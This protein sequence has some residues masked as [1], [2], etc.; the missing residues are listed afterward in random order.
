MVSGETAERERGVGLEL[1]DEDLGRLRYGAAY[2][3]QLARHA[4]VLA[5][6]ER[7]S[8]SAGVIL[9]VE[10]EPVVTIGKRPESPGH[11]LVDEAGL[12]ARGV[13]LC[14]T[15]RGGDVTYHGPGQLVV[16]P[17]VDLKRLGL[18]LHAY[19]RALEEAVI[20][21]LGVFGVP[22]ER[23]ATATG[24]WVRRGDGEPAKVCAMGVRVRRWVSLH[25][26]ALNVTTD[27][28]GFGVIVPCGLAGRPVTSVAELLGS[29]P[30]G[31]SGPAVTAEAVRPVLVERV[32]RALLADG[33]AG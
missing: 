17:V 2:E 20:E 3:A 14:R 21:T 29:G 8:A 28:R 12:R 15:D 23:D 25:G 24:V 1:A 18:G 11:L 13:E 16:Y 4:E 22:G 6:R 30:S 19:M 31:P 10:H 27:L 26:L 9:T 33:L 32:R 7:G 5:A